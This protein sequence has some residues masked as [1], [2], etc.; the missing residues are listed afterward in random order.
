MHKERYS[1][2]QISY[3][4]IHRP[5]NLSQRFP[6]VRWHLSSPMWVKNF[7][8]PFLL[9]PSWQS[10]VRRRM[11]SFRSLT[12]H[13]PPSIFNF[14]HFSDLSLFT[15][16]FLG[17]LFFIFFETKFCVVI[18]VRLILC[19]HEKGK[20]YLVNFGKFQGEIPPLE[21]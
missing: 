2:L 16:I 10:V 6:A 3:L 15:I 17:L 18:N 14:K 11:W 9:F 19:Q 20:L 1:D 5:F 13:F 4:D 7:K 12:C 21:F 8:K